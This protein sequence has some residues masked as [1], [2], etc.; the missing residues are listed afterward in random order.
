MAMNR[1]FI[2]PTFGPNW[3]SRRGVSI[4]A[5]AEHVGA[6]EVGIYRGTWEPLFRSQGMQNPT[7]RIRMLDGFNEGW[8]EFENGAASSRK[9]EVAPKTVLQTLVEREGK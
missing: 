5:W 8:I 2:A 1:S 4:R 7:P 3:A 9:G 6:D